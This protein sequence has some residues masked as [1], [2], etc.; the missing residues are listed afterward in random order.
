MTEPFELGEPDS[1]E[2]TFVKRIAELEEQIEQ[3]KISLDACKVRNKQYYKETNELKAHLAQHELTLN[4]CQ[5]ENAEY[6]KIVNDIDSKLTQTKTLVLV[7]KANTKLAK[8][9]IDKLEELVEKLIE[10]HYC[11]YSEHGDYCW[12]CDL[13]EQRKS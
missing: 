6:E 10:A 12:V 2:G 8:N 11:V 3:L 7:Y 1:L 13:Y 4:I 9:K 5:K